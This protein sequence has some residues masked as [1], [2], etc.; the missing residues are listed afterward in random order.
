M[1][2]DPEEFVERTEL[3]PRMFTF[4]NCELLAEGKILQHQPVATAKSANDSSAPEPKQVKHGSQVITHGILGY[5]PMLLNSKVDGIVTRDK[6][7]QTEFARGWLDVPRKNV[8]V[9]HRRASLDGLKDEILRA[10]RLY[11]LVMPDGETGFDANRVLLEAI[12]AIDHTWLNA[13]RRLARVAL[14]AS[15]SPRQQRPDM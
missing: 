10:V 12:D 11:H 13:D 1:G 5:A 9:T 4:Q 2:H 15:Q 6:F 8:V 14:G 3:R 7:V